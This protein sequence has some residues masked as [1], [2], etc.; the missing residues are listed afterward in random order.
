MVLSPKLLNFALLA[1]AT[2]SATPVVQQAGSSEF[3]SSMSRFLQAF[4][5]IMPCGYGEI[6]VLAPVAIPFYEF[7]VATED[8]SIAGNVTNIQVQGL[9][10]FEVL[11]A[12]DYGKTGEA[13]YDVLFPKIQLLGF[14]KVDGFINIGGFKLPIR[15]NDVINEAFSDLRFVGSY[16]FANS[17]TN[18]SGL[19]IV[20]FQQSIY[21][22]G[23]ELD[24][25]NKLWDISTNNFWNRW[26]KTLIP[27]ALEEIQPNITN[28][29][30]QNFV[31]PKA[32]DLLANVTMN[33]LVNFFQSKA[34]LW[35]NANCQA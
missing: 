16:S 3:T 29:L 27:L 6:P 14:A 17:Q 2:V 10:S 20:D 21:L 1:L 15:Q 4:K 25:W 11:S 22:A 8:L 13:S 31:I 18:S 19:R 28:F 26:I 24:N 12:S 35:D 33:E 5:S 32:N 9:D 23:V 34:K 7:E 30:Y